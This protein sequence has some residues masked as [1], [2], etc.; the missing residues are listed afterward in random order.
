M[1]GLWGTLLGIGGSPIGARMDTSRRQTGWQTDC[2]VF[3]Y[4]HCSQPLP[5]LISSHFSPVPGG[6]TLLEVMPEFQGTK[7]PPLSVLSLVLSASPARLIFAPRAH[8][9]QMAPAGRAA[10]RAASNAFTHMHTCHAPSLPRSLG[11]CGMLW[12][13]AETT[14]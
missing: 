3:G 5:P 10:N 6:A 11:S 8:F 9:T 7:L 2:Y 1:P 4:Q 13:R 14:F 12:T